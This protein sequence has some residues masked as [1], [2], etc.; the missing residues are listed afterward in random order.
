MIN[1]FEGVGKGNAGE[2]MRQN[3]QDTRYNNQKISNNQIRINKH[4]DITGWI[5]AYVV[6]IAR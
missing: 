4:Q 5:P 3:N 2:T 6:T 1:T